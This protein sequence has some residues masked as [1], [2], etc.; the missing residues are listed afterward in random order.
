MLEIKN[1]S[2]TF[3]LDSNKE[4]DRL[5]LDNLSVSIKDGEFVT[6]I[7][8]NGSGKTTL[9]NMIAGVF[10]S[11][12]GLIILNGK[13][14]TKTKEHRRAKMIGRVF[15][16][17]M[18]G[19]V[20]TM[21]VEE[22]LSLAY[23]RGLR[24]TLRWGLTG[25]NRDRFESELASLHLGLESRLFAKAGLL[26]GGQRQ[27]L[28]LVMATLRRPELLLLDEHTAALDPK[29]AKTVMDLTETIVSDN[30]LTTIMITH[31]MKDAI[32]YGN[33]LLMMSEGHIILDVSGNAKN[34]LTI[35]ELIKK[36]SNSGDE[37]PD[38]MLLNK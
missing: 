1:L 13:D 35:E 7:G 27:A 3:R 12:E 23:R 15:Q 14:I 22:N 10:P 33:R 24:P 6:I 25:R 32:R 8:G 17:P 28:T 31:N 26:S 11:D 2:K 36:F 5:A 30:N 4:N 34:Q 18:V 9:L 19:T 21:S 37:L 29:T 20:A 38:E 16:D